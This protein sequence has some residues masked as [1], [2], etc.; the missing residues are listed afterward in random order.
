MSCFEP[1]EWVND[2]IVQAFSLFVQKRNILEVGSGP[3]RDCKMHIGSVKVTADPYWNFDRPRIFLTSP[4]HMSMLKEKKR[5]FDRAILAVNAEIE[6]EFTDII[7]V[8]VIERFCHWMLFYIDIRSKNFHFFYF[9][10][11]YDGRRDVAFL[12]S[13]IF[14][15]I[16]YRHGSDIGEDLQIQEWPLI[17]NPEFNPSKE[18][19]NLSGV[20][21][22]KFIEEI[23][24]GKKPCTKTHNIELCR[25]W[26]ALFLLC[27]VI[28]KG[29]L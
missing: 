25:Q 10:Q 1:G 5:N 19:A 13:W 7:M 2:S 11:F 8:P 17:S 12:R 26:F 16:S 21:L 28:P 4:F 20:I 9:S 15:L 18:K 22:M 27:G 14:D 24:R 23:E 29:S 3:R 6:T